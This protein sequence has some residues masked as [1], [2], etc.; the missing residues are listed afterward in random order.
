MRGG[1]AAQQQRVELACDAPAVPRGGRCV[2]AVKIHPDSALALWML[3]ETLSAD[4]VFEGGAEGMCA[5]VAGETTPAADWKGV[6]CDARGVPVSIDL[7]GRGIMRPLSAFYP[8][9]ASFD[10]HTIDLSNNLIF[11]PLD[12]NLVALPSLRKLLLNNNYL[13]GSVPYESFGPNL[14]ELDV[15][16]NYLTGGVPPVVPVASSPDALLQCRGASNCFQ[17]AGACGGGPGASQRPSAYCASVCGGVSD[18][19]AMCN[20]AADC[21]PPGVADGTGVAGVTAGRKADPVCVCD[22]PKVFMGGECVVPDDERLGGAQL[23]AMD[24]VAAKAEEAEG[25]AVV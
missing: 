22:A 2:T 1:Q 3:S 18:Y 17:D 11:G 13:V 21:L 7:S 16:D 23:A 19:S 6:V 12:A 24:A 8:T 9:L 5:L 10:L 14:W 20:G 15:S 4:A 25:A